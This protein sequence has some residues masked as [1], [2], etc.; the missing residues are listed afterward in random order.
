ME[1]KPS[2]LTGDDVIQ[3]ATFRNNFKYITRNK[4]ISLTVLGRKLGI[5]PSTL[6]YRIYNTKLD[7]DTIQ[8]IAD[9][10]G[11]TIDDLFDED[12]NPWNFGKSAEEIAELNAKKKQERELKAKSNKEDHT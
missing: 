5:K 11:C 3:A 12:G 9:A 7:D 6:Q 10:I 2:Y 1:K 8:K 4:K